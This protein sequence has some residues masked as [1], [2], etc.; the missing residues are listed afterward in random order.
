M[1]LR[2]Y[3]VRRAI[4]TCLCST[5]AA[6]A[7]WANSNPFRNDAHCLVYLEF[8]RPYGHVVS[9]AA[10]GTHSLAPSSLRC[11]T[12]SGVF[13]H[14]RGNSLPKILMIENCIAGPRNIVTAGNWS[15]YFVGPGICFPSLSTCPRQA[16]VAACNSIVGIWLEGRARRMSQNSRQHCRVQSALMV[17]TRRTER[18]C[19]S[20]KYLIAPGQ[21]PGTIRSLM[22]PKTTHSRS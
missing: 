10:F 6:S 9:C 15:P 16:A 14:A 8:T 21:K 22:S 1:T 3:K 13:G 4:L 18:F 19:Q 2:A 20:A 7:S 5:Q 17:F 11:V 12:L